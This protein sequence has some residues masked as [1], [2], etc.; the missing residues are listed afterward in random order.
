MI[1]SNDPRDYP[2]IVANALSTEADVA[3]M[4]AAVKFVRKIA[5]H[6]GHGRDHRRGDSARPVDHFRRRT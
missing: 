5:V 4:L 2:K 3:E 1:R 6:A